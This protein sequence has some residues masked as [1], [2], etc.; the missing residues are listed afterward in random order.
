MRLLLDTCSLIWLA[1]EPAR[2]SS[3]VAAGVDA[4]LT[5]LLSDCSVMELCLKWSAGKLTLPQPPRLWVE[6]QMRI[7]RLSGLPV[8]RRHHYRST[9]LPDHHRDPFDRL[10]VAQ[11]I[12]ENLT[13]A[14]PDPE[15]R[16]YPVSTLW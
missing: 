4:G 15:I 6:E 3:A 2:L 11:A 7:W 16:R 14:T 8:E 9:E 1:A 5:L 10:L 12:E 13:I